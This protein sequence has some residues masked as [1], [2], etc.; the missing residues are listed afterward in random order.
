MT[1]DLGFRALGSA[2][3]PLLGRW[4]ARAHVAQWWRAPWDAEGVAAEY[5]PKIDGREPTRVFVIVLGGT[6]VGWVQWYRWADYPEHAGQLG[7]DETAAGLDLAIGEP[8]LLGRGLGPR[9]LRRFVEGVV[10]ADPAITA[11]ICDPEVENQRSLRAFAR[12][13]FSV[14]RRVRR[15]DEDGDRLVMRRGRI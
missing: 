11:C 5:G 12:A 3:L 14:V 10:F 13:G 7:A 8:E 1:D 9:V 6:D 15:P 4:L 2:D